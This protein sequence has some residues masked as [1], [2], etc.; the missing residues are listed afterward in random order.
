VKVE[1]IAEG[2][3]AE[4]ATIADEKTTASLKVKAGERPVS[5]T[6]LVRAT[7]ETKAGPVTAEAR[8]EVVVE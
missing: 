8:A 7:I 2:L 4:A 1:L 3:S 6:V 5:Q